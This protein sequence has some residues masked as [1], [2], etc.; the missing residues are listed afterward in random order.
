MDNRDKRETGY[1]VSNPSNMDSFAA[2][3][4]YLQPKNAKK[5]KGSKVSYKKGQAAVVDNASAYRRALIPIAILAVVFILATAGLAFFS[6]MT[7]QNQENWLESENKRI[8][9]ENEQLVTEYAE[10]QAALRSEIDEM[11]SVERPTPQA[12][13][14]DILELDNFPLEFSEPTSVSKAE[15]YTGGLIV[16]N[17]LNPLPDDYE[18]FIEP[19]LKSVGKETGGKIQ[20]KD[21]NVRLL[22][23]ALTALQEMFNAAAQAGHGDYIIREGYRSTADQTLLF[24]NMRSKLSEKYSGDILYEKTKEKVNAPGTSEFQSGLAVEIGLYNKDNPDISKQA[25][26]ESDAGRWL[27]DNSWRYGFVFRFPIEDYP[28]A[29]TLDKSNLTGVSIRLR[30]FRYVGVA[31]ASIMQQ[32]NFVLEEFVNYMIEHPHLAIYEDGLLKYELFRIHLGQ[33]VGQTEDVQKPLSVSEFSSSFDN[34]WGI[35][36]SYY[37]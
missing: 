20:V 22:P 2:K 18:S 25:L 35:I 21:Y 32:K 13:G 31:A 29:E 7:G 4:D 37:H 23:E 12:E 5:Q 33:A 11:V 9:A 14:W 28:Y 19:Q 10:Q 3:Y 27:L 1:I 26:N 36:T 30:V 8:A 34:L 16:V 6:G 24:E 15:L 17:S